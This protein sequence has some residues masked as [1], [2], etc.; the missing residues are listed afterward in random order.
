M[1]IQTVLSSIISF[2]FFAHNGKSQN[3]LLLLQFKPKVT[4]IRTFESS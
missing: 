1:D 4:S 2:L 3:D